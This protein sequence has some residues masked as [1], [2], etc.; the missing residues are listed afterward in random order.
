MELQPGTHKG[1]PWWCGRVPEQCR[2][3]NLVYLFV[4]LWANFLIRSKQD[5]R[6]VAYCARQKMRFD[7]SLGGQWKAVANCHHISLT[8]VCIHVCVCVCVCVCVYRAWLGY[9]RLKKKNV[10][11]SVCI[12]EWVC[13]LPFWPQLYP[14]GLRAQCAKLTETRQRHSPGVSELEEHCGLTHNN[15]DPQESHPI[16]CPP[17]LHC[18]GARV[19][20]EYI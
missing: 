14:D 15:T 1:L 10:C 6:A 4:V 9:V 11:I 17:R 5:D 7:E 16:K 2:D 20:T 8:E 12:C 19:F 13:F 18:T 3:R